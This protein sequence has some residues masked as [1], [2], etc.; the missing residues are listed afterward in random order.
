M[1]SQLK[2]NPGTPTQTPQDRKGRN[3]IYESCGYQA[4]FP[5]IVPPYYPQV[6]G[7]H[8]CLTP[9]PEDSRHQPTSVCPPHHDHMRENLPRAPPDIGVDGR[10]NDK[11]KCM[12]V[13]FSVFWSHK[14]QPYNLGT[15][16]PKRDSS[17][18]EAVLK[19]F[20]NVNF[21]RTAVPFGDKLLRF[22]WLVPKTGLQLFSWHC[23]LL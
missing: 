19:G 22:E 21:F 8:R 17:S 11:Q 10:P 15:L 6:Q 16:P 18:L 13:L 9:F 20:L 7:Q 4:P 3:S 12:P 23:V 2:R 5:W 14:S 1:P